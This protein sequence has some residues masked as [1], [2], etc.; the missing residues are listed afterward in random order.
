ML[1]DFFVSK[2][3]INIYYVWLFIAELE[4]AGYKVNL[5]INTGNIFS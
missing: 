1:K 5:L 2:V 3:R 4:K